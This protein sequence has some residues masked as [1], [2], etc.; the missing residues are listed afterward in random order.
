M[1][2]LLHMTKEEYKALSEDEKPAKDFK[3]IS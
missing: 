2:S 1:H 3:R